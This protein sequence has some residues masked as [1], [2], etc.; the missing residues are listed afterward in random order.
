MAPVGAPDSERASKDGSN[1]AL[2]AAC[3]RRF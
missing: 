2:E 1:G 3:Q